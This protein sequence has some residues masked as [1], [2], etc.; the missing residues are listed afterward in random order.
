MS[1]SVIGNLAERANRASVIRKGQFTGFGAVAYFSNADRDSCESS[2]A[3][4]PN[5]SP[6]ALSSGRIIRGHRFRFPVAVSGSRIAHRSSHFRFFQ[7]L[8]SRAGQ[9]ASQRQSRIDVSRNP[10]ASWV[11]EVGFRIEPG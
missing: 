11:G 1:A 5:Y 3:M 7:A 10:A 2:A 8:R 4:T 9:H 6:I